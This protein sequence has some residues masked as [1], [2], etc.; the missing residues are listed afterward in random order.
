VADYTISLIEIVQALGV[1]GVIGFLF[2][3]GLKTFKL[4]PKEAKAI[5]RHEPAK[6][7]LA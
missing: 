1:F 2:V 6:V 7:Q 3:W 4:L 5:V